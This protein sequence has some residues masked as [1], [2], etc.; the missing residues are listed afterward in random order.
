VFS[1][2]LEVLNAQRSL[3]DAEL[4]SVQS[5][6]EQLVALVRLYKALG[7]GWTPPNETT[8]PTETKAQAMQ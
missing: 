4:D 8:S 7:G 3:F 5:I 6:R 2:Y 1:D